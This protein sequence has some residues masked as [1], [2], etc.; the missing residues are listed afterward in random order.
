MSEQTEASKQQSL[1]IEEI[2][3]S[4][5]VQ[6][7]AKLNHEAI[8]EFADAMKEGTQFP[9]VVVFHDGERHWCADGFHRVYAAIKTGLDR[10]AAEV[11]EGGEREAI[12]HSV[13]ANRAHGIRRTPE[14]KHRAVNILL[15]DPEWAQWSDGKIAQIAAVSTIKPKT[16][17]A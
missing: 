15:D 9:P 2:R 5:E 17:D 14:D 13:G 11:R 7:R 8:G 1:L 16:I 12:L 10:I 3:L 4:D 6:S